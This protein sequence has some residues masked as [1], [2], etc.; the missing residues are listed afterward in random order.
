MHLF[1]Y[2]NEFETQTKHTF[3]R[4]LIEALI[5]QRLYVFAITCHYTE[6]IQLLNPSHVSGVLAWWSLVT[7]LRKVPLLILIRTTLIFAYLPLVLI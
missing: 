2:I 6:G 1:N 4:Y 3:S 5:K 7:Q